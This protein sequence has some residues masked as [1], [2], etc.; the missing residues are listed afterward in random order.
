MRSV[1]WERWFHARAC[2]I[3]RVSSVLGLQT[4]RLSPSRWRCVSTA[5]VPPYASHTPLVP[6]SAQIPPHNRSYHA[7][8]GREEPW[9]EALGLP[10]AALDHP[11]QSR[12][13]PRGRDTVWHV[14][15]RHL[16][17]RSGSDEDTNQSDTAPSATGLAEGTVAA[18]PP[19]KRSWIP[20]WL[21]K[22]HIVAGDG[23]SRWWVPP[24][25]IATH[26]SIGSVYAW[27]IFNTPLT[28]ELGV[29]ASSAGDWSLASVVPVFSTAIVCL[30][31][32]AAVAGKWLEEVRSLPVVCMLHWRPA[33]PHGGCKQVGPRM[34]GVTS[35]LC[36]GGGFVLGGV[37]VA[38]HSLP[39]LY[40]GYGVLGGC[41]LGLGYGQCP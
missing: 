8:S 23:F 13:N 12:Q 24:A 32:S 39:L 15:S 9:G 34:V 31:L 11:R 16:S 2:S 33:A 40:L 28:R 35:A 26:L 6:A 22:D 17:S 5:S 21:L 3:G 20:K 10:A 41:G 18:D 36:W 29:V 1:H 4:R 37:G 30:G 19:P 25:S 27:S 14:S 38:M 7:S